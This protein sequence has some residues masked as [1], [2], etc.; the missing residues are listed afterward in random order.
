MKSAMVEE[1]WTDNEICEDV[2]RLIYLYLGKHEFFCHFTV[3]K[4]SLPLPAEIFCF[5]YIQSFAYMEA[6]CRVSLDKVVFASKIL[7]NRLKIK[8]L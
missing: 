7:V 8:G 1:L 5:L 2:V 4:T 6:I 3:K